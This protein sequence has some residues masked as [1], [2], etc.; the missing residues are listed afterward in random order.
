MSLLGKVCVNGNGFVRTGEFKKRLDKELDGGLG[1]G[2]VEL[3]ERRKRKMLCMEDLKL[4]LRLGDGYLGQSPVIAASILNSRCL[5]TEGI[6]DIYQ[7]N[8]TGMDSVGIGG[9]VWKVDFDFTNG[10]AGDPMQIDGEEN[11]GWQ[12][13]DADGLDDVLDDVLNLADL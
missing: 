5:D 8:G 10:D 1:V 3:E 6:E 7:V 13:G 12:G 11:N 2:A 9:E 4:A